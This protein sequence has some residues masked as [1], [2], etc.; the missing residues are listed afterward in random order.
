MDTEQATHIVSSFIATYYGN[1]VRDNI[2]TIME[3]YSDSSSTSV[4]KL[5]EAV[6]TSNRGKAEIRQSLER[7]SGE[8]GSRKV[9][10][11][12]ADSIPTTD[13]SILVSVGGLL[14]TRLAVQ[15]FTQTFVL[16]STKNRTRTLFIAAESLRFVAIEPEVIPNGAVLVAP[17]DDVVA[18]EPEAPVAPRPVRE[19]KPR[20]PKAPKKEEPVAAVAAPAPPPP[21]EAPTAAARPQREPRERKERVPREKKAEEAAKPADAA[22]TA[23]SS[24]VKKPLRA[25]TST[26]RLHEVPQTIRLSVLKEAV[27]KFGEVVD[28]QWF[29]PNSMDC[30]V[31]FKLPTSVK[32][33]VFAK[34]FAIDGTFIK[35]SFFYTNPQ[36]AK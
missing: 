8:I 7:L 34:T 21:A 10:I 24:E 17:G 1:F 31:E 27:G 25:P 23:E 12:T 16:A 4:A 29:G 35:R 14:Y 30:L 9:H 2:H 18:P 3:M 36:P 33:L 5:N 22:A 28:A 6:A 32:N 11:T 15:T 20:E 19:R 26:V 13:G